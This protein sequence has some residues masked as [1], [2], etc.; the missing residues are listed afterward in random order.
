MGKMFSISD[1]ITE[2]LVEAPRVVEELLLLLKTERECT[3]GSSELRQHV[4]MG[5]SSFLKL[6]YALDVTHFIAKDLS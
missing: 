1:W 6:D 2:S 5:S 3:V 4:N